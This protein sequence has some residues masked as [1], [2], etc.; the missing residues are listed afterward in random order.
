MWGWNRRN[1]SGPRPVKDGIKAKKQRG[2]IGETW[3]SKR[4]LEVL[5]S[6]NIGARLDRG[7][8]YARRGQVINIDIEEGLVSAK[9]QGS[10]STPY[11]I[12]I[13]LKALSKK[14]WEQVEKALVERAIF[15]AS[16]LAG[17]MPKDIEEAFI[18]VNLSLFPSRISDLN[19]ECSCPDW[20]NP[21][22][23]IAAVYYILAE[24]FDEDPFLLFT[25]RGRTKE[26][27]IEKL[28]SLRGVGTDLDIKNNSQK[29]VP[30]ILTSTLPEVPIP[31]L[32]DSLENFWQAR[33]SF[34]ELSFQ[35]E[36]VSVPDAMI[37]QLEPLSLSVA[38]KK[39][40]DILSEIYRVLSNKAIDK[41]F[42]K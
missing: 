29:E 12:K 38:D 8:S 32:N 28:R 15:L 10:R 31:S 13:K 35:L 25:W 34:S 1:S 36:K 11:K 39:V 19:T 26:E 40:S 2:T 18:G 41:A 24:Q 23:H 33:A 7:R 20:S 37:R 30:N 6:F 16:L 27:L 9:V 42:N 22:K 3:W 4:F 14:E 17:E 21:C 5:H